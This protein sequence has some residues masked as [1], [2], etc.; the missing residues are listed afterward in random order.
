MDKRTLIGSLL[1]AVALSFGS[2]ARAEV[3][4]VKLASQYGIGY[5]P[6]TVMQV[7][8]LVEKHLSEE[9]KAALEAM[10]FK[11]LMDTLKQ[12]LAEQ[13]E[14]HREQDQLPVVVGDLELGDPDGFAE[15]PNCGRRIPT[16]ADSGEG[17]HARVVPALDVSLIDQLE[18][19][20]LTHDGVVE[21]QA[22]EF[23][24]TG[25]RGNREIF[26]KPVIE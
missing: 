1:A 8:K 6:L 4:E 14:R 2:H 3:D 5:L 12:R 11:Q 21:I 22:G 24:L 9:D 13:R 26:E 10:G 15:I 25:A 17:R 16:A 19:L 20:A 23:D 18:Q 7:D